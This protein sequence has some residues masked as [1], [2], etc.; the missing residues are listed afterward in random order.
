MDARIEGQIRG[1]DHSIP[2]RATGRPPSGARPQSSAPTKAAAG[3]SAAVDATHE[4]FDANG[5]GVIENWS[6]AH[7]GDSFET[8]D[9]PPS[10]Q[11][12]A[13]GRRTSRTQPDI[14]TRHAHSTD[15]STAP[16][17]T[18][19]AIH[20][21]L[22]AYKSDGMAN[23]PAPTTSADAAPVTNTTPAPTPV[24]QTAPPVALPS[25]GS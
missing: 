19:A 11:V 18:A 22:G 8:F 25:A 21:A 13:N 7:G 12:G 2:T 1:V 4:V 20:K 9:P 16:V 15:P 5:D 23:P 6:Y 10:G 17:N 24:P 14:A 3:G